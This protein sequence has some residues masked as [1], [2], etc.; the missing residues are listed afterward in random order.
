MA[1]AIADDLG[2]DLDRTDN[3][4]AAGRGLDDAQVAALRSQ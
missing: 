4:E 1:R 2:L 3:I